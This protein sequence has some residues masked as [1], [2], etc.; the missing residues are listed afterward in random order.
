M[1]EKIEI[2]TKGREGDNTEGAAWGAH[3]LESSPAFNWYAGSRGPEEDKRHPGWLSKQNRK[4][5]KHRYGEKRRLQLEANK[6]GGTS[7]NGK[8]EQGGE[9]TSNQGGGTTKD[10][11]GESE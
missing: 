10:G 3:K 8:K 1:P 9:G 7:L 4:Q 5:K 11:P 6:E 2:E